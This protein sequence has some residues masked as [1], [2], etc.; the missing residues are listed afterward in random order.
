MKFLKELIP[1][2]H[3]LRL[4]Y[5]KLKAFVA[6]VWY[7]FPA[8]KLIV[9]GIT[10][11]NGK[12]TTVNLVNN[13]LR[14]AGYS[15]GMTSTVN[16][17]IGEMKWVNTTKQSTLGP[18]FLQRML[19]RMVMEGC[20]YAVIEVT[21]HAIDQYRTL[22]INFDVA[23]IT[24][25][26]PDHVE[27][28]GS[29]N[30]YLRTKGKLF[31]Q[32]SRGKKKL[33]VPKV[34][35]LNSDDKYYSYFD[36]FLADQKVVY[37]LNNATV[38]PTDLVKSAEGA[39]FM[40]NVPNNAVKVEINM[41]GEFSVYNALAAS[42]VALALQVPLENIRRGLK[43][44]VNVPGRFEHV[45]NDEEFS[46]VVDYAHTP[47]ALESLIKLYKSL[48]PGRVFVVFGAT[49]GGRD[50][51]K[52]MVMGRVADE[53]ADVVIVTNDDPYTEDEWGI[54]EQVSEGI[55]RNEGDLFWKIPDRREAIRLAL[56]LAKAGDCV[57]VAGKGAEEVIMIGGRALPWNDKKVIKELLSAIKNVEI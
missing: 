50:K 10:G 15:V 12:T 2:R 29:F 56:Y 20:K 52:R 53:N 19:R 9:V 4:A 3:P 21:S 18:F 1:E 7:R 34:L 26:T 51:A 36:K 41:P 38:Y 25:I 13:I 33:G 31:E 27:Y 8:N 5:H 22:G 16:F 28:H 37:G 17:Q 32:V 40:L 54:V 35:I 44:S 57:L 42:A 14:D 39:E 47:E 46:V 45:E 43:E 55:K 23:L 11:T 30:A 49:G 48:T 6:A 24:N